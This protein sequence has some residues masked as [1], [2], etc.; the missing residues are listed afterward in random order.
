VKLLAQVT[1][2]IVLAARLKYQW[3][4]A[5]PGGFI[6]LQQQITVLD[7]VRIQALVPFFFFDIL[8]GSFEMMTKEDAREFLIPQVYRLHKMVGLKNE[9]P[10]RFTFDEEYIHGAFTSYML[11]Q[12]Y[13]NHIS[14]NLGDES[15]QGQFDYRPHL[16]DMSFAELLI[17]VLAHEMRHA[18][19]FENGWLSTK[20]FNTTYVWNRPNQHRLIMAHSEYHNIR[21]VSIE[22][23]EAI[24]WEADANK[25]AME[26]VAAWRNDPET[27]IENYPKRRKGFWHRISLAFT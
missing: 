17:F 1:A 10:V 15:V 5:V 24:P 4:R 19:Q 13:L 3:A 8:S 12:S 26:A 2:S 18:F 11:S 9:V 7:L 14:I 6:N 22:A 20:N 25:F 16:R 23:Y 27:K 21:L